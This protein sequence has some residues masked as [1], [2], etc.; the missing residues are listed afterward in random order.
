MIQT[1]QSKKKFIYSYR[2]I[3]KELDENIKNTTQNTFK[4][5]NHLISNSVNLILKN[6]LAFDDSFPILFEKN[7]KEITF[8]NNE[9]TAPNYSNKH[10]ENLKH[11]NDNSSKID[12]NE[13][14][15][16]LNNKN[17]IIFRICKDFSKIKYHNHDNFIKIDRNKNYKSYNNLY[18]IEKCNNIF[19]NRNNNSQKERK[20]INNLNN[21]DNL[22]NEIKVKKNNKM[23]YINKSLIKPK[24]KKKI[25]DF[26]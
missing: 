21:K 16:N 25:Y 24:N 13:N 3:I 20:P 17:K 26:T 19:I 18:K 10:I 22:S 7:Y 15:N 8:L 4:T 2:N 1:H 23:I 9:K 5:N 14:L 6:D 12:K 11:L